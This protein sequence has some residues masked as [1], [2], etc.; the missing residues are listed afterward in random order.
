MLMVLAIGL[1]FCVGCGQKEE[2]INLP[3]QKPVVGQDVP[4]APDLH[5]ENKEKKLNT[6]KVAKPVSAMTDDEK[7][8]N[9]LLYGNEEGKS[10]LKKTKPIKVTGFK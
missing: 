5:K 6:G 1:L 9:K 10:N 7:L 4:V 3:Q 2:E 8:T